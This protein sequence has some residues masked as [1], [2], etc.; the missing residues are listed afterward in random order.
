MGMK[1][2]WR[3]VDETDRA[4]KCKF[5][6]NAQRKRNRAVEMKWISR[7]EIVCVVLE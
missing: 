6:C 3:S 5:N 4:M 7:G 2:T 1:L